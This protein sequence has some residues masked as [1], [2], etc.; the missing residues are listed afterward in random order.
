MMWARSAGSALFLMGALLAGAADTQAQTAVTVAAGPA[1]YDLSGTGWSGVAELHVERGLTSWLRV[2]VGG[3]A[4]RYTTQGDSKVTMLIPDASL[5]V[6]AQGRVPVYLGV[7]GGY[8]VVTSGSQPDELSLHAV[9]GVSYDVGSVV[10]RPEV[11]VR[12]IDPWT[13]TIGGF[14]LG[15][16]F[17]LG[18]S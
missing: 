14:T 2:E 12:T 10:L 11:K 17:P 5:V 6:Q 13:G 16:S 15:V 3:G 8:S 4:F 18:G 9:A 7:G 1:T